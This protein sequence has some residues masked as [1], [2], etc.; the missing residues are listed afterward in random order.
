[1]AVIV[2]QDFG[3]GT[4]GK[5]AAQAYYRHRAEFVLSPWAHHCA[6]DGSTPTHQPAPH[7]VLYSAYLSEHQLI[8]HIA[9][10][11]LQCTRFTLTC[12]LRTAS[13][14][15]RI[16]PQQGGTSVR[17]IIHCG[18]Y[19][20]KLGLLQGSKVWANVRKCDRKRGNNFDKWR[21]GTVGHNSICT[22]LQ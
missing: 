2:R 20:R 13:S 17:C 6:S 3:Q 22:K 11:L 16:C 21:L 1:M 18:I 19:Y 7:Y 15:G 4:P 8:T 10:V 5:A 14:F 12:S 9:R